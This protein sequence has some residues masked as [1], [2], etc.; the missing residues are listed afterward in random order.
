MAATNRASE[1]INASAACELGTSP[2]A[3]AL[4]SWYAAHAQ[5]RRLWAVNQTDTIL[6]VM[7]IEPTLD[8]YDALPIWF[9]N[10]AAWLE[11]LASALCL[12][13]IWSCSQGASCAAALSSMN[14]ALIADIYWRE[15]FC[16]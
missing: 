4:A 11:E 8:G 14:D 16:G 6:I 3:P 12:P 7:R 10:T 5:V 2:E 13:C 9:A 1:Q 15:E